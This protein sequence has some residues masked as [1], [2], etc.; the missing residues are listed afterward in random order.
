MIDDNGGSF[1]AFR[2]KQAT[3]E[4]EGKEQGLITHHSVPRGR[5]RAQTRSRFLISHLDLSFLILISH[6]PLFLQKVADLIGSRRVNSRSA[7]L[8]VL[9]L[10]FFVDD[11]SS[12]GAVTR[13]LVI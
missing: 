5:S 6:L 13:T 9:D 8:D 3:F 11:E 7:G 2:R 1:G 12:A 4:P 10:A